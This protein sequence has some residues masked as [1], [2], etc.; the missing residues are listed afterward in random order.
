VSRPPSGR[1]TAQLPRP[2]ARSAAVP[3]VT[4][5]RIG[6]PLLESSPNARRAFGFLRGCR[7]A[8]RAQSGLTLSFTRPGDMQFSLNGCLCVVGLRSSLRPPLHGGCHAVVRPTVTTVSR[9]GGGDNVRCL[10]W[11]NCVCGA[12]DSKRAANLSAG[13]DPA[14]LGVRLA[15]IRGLLHRG[16]DQVK[17]RAHDVNGNGLLCGKPFAHELHFPLQQIHDDRI[18]GRRLPGVNLGA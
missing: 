14:G 5:R 13:G 12:V 6:L 9:A 8:R 1:E 17:L 15:A 10:A 16:G 18:E 4:Q 3:S 11:S 7:T 2:V